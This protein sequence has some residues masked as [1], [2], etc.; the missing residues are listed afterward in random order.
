[1]TQ[2]T[3]VA[4]YS[5]RVARAVGCRQAALG[6]CGGRSGGLLVAVARCEAALS[7][8]GQGVQASRLTQAAGGSLA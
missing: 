3:T 2:Q 6:G 4:G 7:A 8:L 1:M 5:R